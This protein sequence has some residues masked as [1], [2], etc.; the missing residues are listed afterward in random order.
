VELNLAPA[1]EWARSHIELSFVLTTLT[2]AAAFVAGFYYSGYFAFYHV[3]SANIPVSLAKNLQTF[4]VILIVA[5]SLAMLIA[6]AERTPAI[7]FGSAFIDNIPFLFLLVLITALAID[8][9]WSNVEFSAQWLA[10]LLGDKDSVDLSDRLTRE[11]VGDL[12]VAMVVGPAVLPPLVVVIASFCRFS[13]SRFVLSQSRAARFAL[14][15][16]Y[17]VL[18]FASARACGHLVAYLDFK[19]VFDNPSVVITLSDGK[20]LGREAPVFIVAQSDSQY[21][22]ATKGMAGEEHPDTWILPMGSVQHLFLAGAEIAPA[23]R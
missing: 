14:L 12:K 9:Y 18:T 19:G 8:L 3:D 23:P 22:I 6:R 11:V 16:V 7:T 17:V 4:L 21:F 15:G 2:A 13:F 10:R 1:I 5:V 20:D